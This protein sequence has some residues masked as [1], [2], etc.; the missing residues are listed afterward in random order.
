[1]HCTLYCKMCTIECSHGSKWLD[2]TLYS[3]RKTPFIT[4]LVHFCSTLYCAIYCKIYFFFYFTLFAVL[5]CKLYFALY[6]IVLQKEVKKRLAYSFRNTTGIASFLLYCT[7]YCILYCMLPYIT[8][9]CTS[10][11]TVQSTVSKKI[12]FVLYYSSYITLHYI[13]TPKWMAYFTLSLRNCTLYFPQMSK[14][15]AKKFY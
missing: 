13:Q 6:C 2:N 3:L 4:T 12:Y 8:I 7:L 1:M 15:L 11:H 14:W 10:Q 9:N 5:Y